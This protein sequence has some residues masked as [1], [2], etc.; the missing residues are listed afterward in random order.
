[1]KREKLRIVG[2]EK[3]EK[4]KYTENIFNENIEEFF[5]NLKKM[6]IKIQETYNMQTRKD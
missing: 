3:G 6:P 2:I 1:M 5:S 4:S